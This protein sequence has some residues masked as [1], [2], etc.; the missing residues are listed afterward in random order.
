M[1]DYIQT[2]QKYICCVS[3]YSPNLIVVSQ[4]KTSFFHVRRRESSDRKMSGLKLETRPPLLIIRKHSNAIIMDT[5]Q[6]AGSW[7]YYCSTR[8]PLQIDAVEKDPRLPAM[9][10]RKISLYS[11]NYP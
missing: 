9:I 5:L 6:D 11:T 2:A 7:R 4:N 3:I 8:Y 1:L 10:V